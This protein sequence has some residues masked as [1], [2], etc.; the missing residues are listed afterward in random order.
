M[1]PQKGA[2]KNLDLFFK[3]CNLFVMKLNKHTLILS[4]RRRRPWG[5]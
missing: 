4:L 2:K 1:N 3:W 5:V